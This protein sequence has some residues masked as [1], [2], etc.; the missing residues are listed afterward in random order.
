[1]TTIHL[2]VIDVPYVD[3][4]GVTTGDVAEI[5]ERKYHVM[6]IFAEAHGEDIA[7]ELANA[8]EGSL[9]TLMMGGSFQSVQS[10][11]LG[12]LTNVDHLFKQFLSNG[13]MES[14][15]YPGVPTKAALTGVN[16]RLKKKK[17]GRRP[18][19]IDTGQYQAS[20]HAWVDNE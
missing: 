20:F 2:G 4:K 7:K 17:G 5:L 13:E 14:L 10:A 12:G 8:V 16:H 11:M 1:M 6:E 15:G 9:E 19:F 3:A 18:S